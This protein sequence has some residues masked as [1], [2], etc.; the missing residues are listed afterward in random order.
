MRRRYDLLFF[1]F[2]DK[3]LQILF[4]NVFHLSCWASCV[5]LEGLQV[6]VSCPPSSDHKLFPPTFSSLVTIS[7]SP[8]S[9]F[10]SNHWNYFRSALVPN[11]SLTSFTAHCTDPSPQTLRPPSIIAFV[12]TLYCYV[13]LNFTSIITRVF[14]L[15]VLL[16]KDKEHFFFFL[17]WN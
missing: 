9:L 16:K 17:F 8:Y 2:S 11:L 10:L 12:I 14:P 1:W 3:T 7:L 15:L 6:I 4:G 13:W 5:A